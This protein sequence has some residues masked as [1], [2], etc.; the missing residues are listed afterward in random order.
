MSM[1]AVG[2]ALKP[3]SLKLVWQPLAAHPAVSDFRISLTHPDPQ[4]AAKH[5]CTRAEH[6]RE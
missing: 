3:F 5:T 4:G 2:P 1:A 6:I